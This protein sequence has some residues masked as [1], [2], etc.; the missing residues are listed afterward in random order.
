MPEI[1]RA[2][3][4]FTLPS[5]SSESFGNV[6]VE[7]MASSLP[8]VATEDP[9]RREIVGGAGI[10]VD[11]TN[12]DEYAK[13]LQRALD[14]KWGDAPRKQAEKFSWDGIANEYEE[15]FKKLIEKK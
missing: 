14:T 15:L 8:I 12:T 5:A 10:F 6:L 4:V 7:A 13:S 9:I 3:D 11:P 1:Y 2:A